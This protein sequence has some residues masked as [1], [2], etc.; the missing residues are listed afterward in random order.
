[1]VIGLQNIKHALIAVMILI[2]ISNE[3][4]LLSD[5]FNLISSL[6]IGFIDFKLK[7][8]L[9]VIWPIISILFVLAIIFRAYS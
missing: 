4:T 6:I 9:G 8:R 1:M 5:V 7:D 2:L 3:S